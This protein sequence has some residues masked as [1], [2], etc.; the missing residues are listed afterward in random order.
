MLL[1]TK[2]MRGYD[3]MDDTRDLLEEFKQTKLSETLKWAEKAE[4]ERAKFVSDYPIESIP[5]L[6]LEGYLIAKKGYGKQDSFC[7]RLRHGM[8]ASMGNAFPN[9]FGIYLR[10]SEL[11]LSPT[12]AKMFG[13]D[14]DGAFRYIKNEIYE[15]LL[16]MGK[17]DYETIQACR[18]NSLFKNKLLLIYFPDKMLPVCARD[19][20]NA[21][22]DCVHLSYDPEE[23]MLVQNRELLDLK[24]S[25]PE[26][27]EWNNSVFMRFCDWLWREKKTLDGPAMKKDKSVIQAADI[28]KELDEEHLLGETREAV[29]RVRVNQGIFRERLLRKRSRCCLCGVSDPALLTASHIKPW[30]VSEPEERLDDDNGFLMCPNHDKL[31]DRGLISFTDDGSILISDVLSTVDRIF[32]NVN[33]SMRLKLTEKNKEYLQYHRENIFVQ[34]QKKTLGNI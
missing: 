21:Y 28:E 6:T 23:D 15:L 26:L 33:E 25:I 32:M 30:S 7:H 1:C 34:N 16:A 20:L 29:I 27:S 11:A 3:N 14:Y 24:E 10:G 22:C 8:V 4:A 18:L 9:V 17:D 12:F 13:H 5:G 19:T 31:F 2:D